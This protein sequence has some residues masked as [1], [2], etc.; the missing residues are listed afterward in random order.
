MQKNSAF[1]YEFF[2]NSAEKPQNF[3]EKK[4]EGRKDLNKQNGKAKSG[5]KHEKNWFRMLKE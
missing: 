3:E 1:Q 4:W 5:K 2:Q